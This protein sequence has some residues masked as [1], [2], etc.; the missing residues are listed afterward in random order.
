MNT[1]ETQD[2]YLSAYLAAA[3]HPIV[4]FYKDSGLTTFAFEEDSRLL[5]LA[6]E[7]Y[8][9][10]AVVSPIRYGNSLKNLKCLIH[11]NHYGKPNTHN[12][13]AAK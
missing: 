7:Y 6:R 10:H 2:F 13:S 4:H 9:D 5:E 8:A 1:Y 12:I 11:S 3:G